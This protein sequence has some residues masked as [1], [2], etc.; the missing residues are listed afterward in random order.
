MLRCFD[1]AVVWYCEGGTVL[2]S[3]NDPYLTS[4]SPRGGRGTSVARWQTRGGP[5]GGG[6]GH[7]VQQN[8][9]DE[10]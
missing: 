9:I 1:C 10:V 6:R 8:S 2:D 4:T 5:R 3:M 7:A